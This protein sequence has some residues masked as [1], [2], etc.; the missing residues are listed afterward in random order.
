[1]EN[2]TRNKM[3]TRSCRKRSNREFNY[4]NGPTP[5]KVSPVEELFVK[6]KNDGRPKSIKGVQYQYSSNGRP[7]PCN[8]L[9]ES[10]IKE[11]VNDNQ[12]E[13]LKEFHHQLNDDTWSYSNKA[14][15]LEEFIIKQEKDDIQPESIEEYHHQFNDIGGPNSSKVAPIEQLN[16]IGEKDYYQLSTLKIDDELTDNSESTTSNLTPSEEL[17]ITDVQDEDDE[18][19]YDDDQTKSQDKSINL[20]HPKLLL[21]S[22]YFKFVRKIKRINIK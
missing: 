10:I 15:P 8:S 22:P 12:T 20:W 18:E 4:S 16:T 2:I 9:E 3:V 17:I 14:N 21:T 7:S 11:E 5:S 6:E 19:E 13:S 1:M